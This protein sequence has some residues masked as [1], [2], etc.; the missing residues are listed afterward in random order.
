MDKK[1]SNN[2]GII[3]LLIVI[4][5]FSVTLG[6]L[7]ATKVIKNN[8]ENTTKENNN[9]NDNENNIKENNDTNNNV[10]QTK[11]VKTPNCDN[12][13]TTFN[14]ITVNL[15]QNLEDEVCVINSLTIN[16]KDITDKLLVWVESYEIYDNNVLIL[17]SDTG[18]TT[19]LIYSVESSSVVLDLTPDNLSGYFVESYNTN[20][21][22]ITINGYECK[23]QCGYESTGN[24]N[25]VFEIKYSDNSFTIPKLIK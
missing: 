14:G 11:L 1:E 23:E 15:K 7:F 4:I 21:E 5:I 25:A 12:S 2:K 6:I 16:G 13:S 19:L 17:S 24:K 18:G 22:V 10:I 9:S 3:I 8:N 20:N